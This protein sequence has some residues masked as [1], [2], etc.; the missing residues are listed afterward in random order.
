MGAPHKHLRAAYLDT[1]AALGVP[2]NMADTDPVAFL[3]AMASLKTTGDPTEPAVLTAIKQTAKGT[4]GK[5]RERPRG[6]GYK[7]G[8]RWA[9]LERPTWG[10][11]QKWILQ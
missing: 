8:E 4:L 6:H 10:L 5:M 3:D 2:P 7:P 1:M 9:A 11:F